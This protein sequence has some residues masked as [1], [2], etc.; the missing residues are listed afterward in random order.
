MAGGNAIRGSR[1]G[2]GPMGEAERG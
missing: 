1:V 2:A